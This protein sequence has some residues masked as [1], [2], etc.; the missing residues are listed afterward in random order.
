MESENL[1]F[2]ASLAR[3]LKA[4]YH[5][6]A[7]DNLLKEAWLGV[8]AAASKGRDKFCIKLE[9]FPYE[10]IKHFTRKG[11]KVTIKTTHKQVKSVNKVYYIYIDWSKEIL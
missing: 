1:D 5:Q 8:S 9:G 3:Q 10:F 11:F 6:E 4:A 2:N 7:F